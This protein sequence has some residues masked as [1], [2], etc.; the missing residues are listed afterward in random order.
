MSDK[1]EKGSVHDPSAVTLE[2]ATERRLVRPGESARHIDLSITAPAAVPGAERPPLSLALVVDRSGSMHGDKLT[3]AKAAAIAVLDRLEPRDRAAVVIFDSD[4]EAIL[5]EGPMTTERKAEARARLAE[6]E[7]G[8]STALHEGWL[9]GCRAI[10]AETVGSLSGD[11]LSRCLLLSDGHANQGLTD[12]EALAAQAAEVRANA[13]VGT[14]TFG[15]GEDYDEGLLAPMAVSGSGQFHNLR[16]LSEITAA[17]AGELRELFNVTARSVQIDIEH[18]PRI[19]PE[20]VSMYQ[21]AQGRKPGTLTID[22]GDL[23]ASEPRH[24]VVRLHFI[25]LVPG[26]AVELRA[27]VTWRQGEDRRAGEWRGLRFECA[28]HSACDAEPRAMA[29]M[30]WVGIHH[31]DKA[32]KEA[33][34]LY[35]RDDFRGAVAVLTSVIHRLR[36]YATRDPDLKK[37]LEELER[38]RKVC[39]EGK[40]SRAMSKEW[41]HQSTSSSRGQRDQRGKRS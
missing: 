23:I 6:V 36:E 33:I 22:V 2:A 41:M 29:V 16:D 19:E 39:K 3:T 13:G 7:A 28:A 38:Q 40:M 14:S 12:P 10:A 34:G 4:V 8:S 1:S 11:R 20:M 24:I 9:T 15:V 17:F 5:P 21:N 25:G 18:D 27:R 32:K 30:H 37:A 26:D 31:A 35:H